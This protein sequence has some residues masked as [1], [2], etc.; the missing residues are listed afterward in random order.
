MTRFT[1]LILM[2]GVAAGLSAQTLSLGT[3]SV[4][5]GGTAHMN[6]MLTSGGSQYA[7]VQCDLV[8]DKTNLTITGVT[9]SA[10]SG[11]SKSASHNYSLSSTSIRFIVAGL[12]QDVIPDGDVVDLTIV[13]NANAPA[14]TYPV[15]VTNTAGTDPN[16]NPLALGASGGSVTVIAVLS[17]TGPSTIPSGYANETYTNTQVNAVGGT[18]PYT[19]SYSGFP[20]GMSVNSTG[21][22]TGTP[23]VSG[24]FSPQVKVTDS[25]GGTATQNYSL[26]IGNALTVTAPTGATLPVATQ[27]AAYTA[28]TAT[29]SGG[30]GSNTWTGSGFPGGLGISSAGVISGTPTANGA[31]NS[32]KITVTDAGG[33]SASQTYS[34][35]V[36]PPL[37][38]TSP[39]S[40][41]TGAVGEVYPSGVSF[42]ATGGSG[43]YTWGATGL[44]NGLGIGATGAITGTPAAGSNGNY[45]VT[46]TATDGNGIKASN[47]AAITINAALSI[48]SS[49]SLPAGAVGE[50]YTG[51]T[52]AATGGVG[53]YTWSATG[54]PPGLGIS[55]SGAI[56]GSPTGGANNY[57]PVLKV[58]DSTGFSVTQ[59]ATLSVNAALAVTAPT[60]ATLP[61]ATQGA[62][63][64]ALTA[65]ASGG[66]GSNTWT[67]SGFPAGLSISGSGSISGT[68]TANGTFNSV[69]IT[70]TDAGGGS[71]SQTY[72]LIVNPPLVVTSP[73]SPP[74]GASGEPYAGT[75]FSATGGSGTYTWTATNLPPGLTIGSTGAITGT[76]TG[77]A[78]TYTVTATAKDSNGVTA[79]NTASIQINPFLAVSCLPNPLPTAALLEAYAG[80]QC[81]ASGGVGTYTYSAST[82]FPSGININSS[83]GAVSGTP[84]VTGSFGPVVK[85]T[86]TGGGT[87]YQ[88]F[89]TLTVNPALAITNPV[90]AS[91]PVATV[92]AAYTALTAAASGGTGTNSWSGTGFPAGLSISSAG[93]ISGTPTASGTF[94][95]VK[96]TVTD[97]GG[98]S[99]SQTYSIQV[100]PQ[101]VVSAPASASLPLG[102]VGE[103][104]TSV[105]FAATGGSG[106]YTGW[107][108]TGVPPGLNFNTNTGSLSGTPTGSGGSYT[109]VVTV[110]DSNSVTANRSYS[111]TV[112]PALAVN[113]PSTLPAG[114]AS[115]AYSA[116]LTAVGGSGVYT[117][118]ATG[119]PAN[120][121]LASATG[122]IGG[123]PVTNAGSPFTVTVTVTDSASFTATKTYSLVVNPLAPLAIS[124]PSSLPAGIMNVAY[125]ATTM[126][127]TGG[128]GG[129]SWSAAGLPP[130]L[131]INPSTGT[132]SGTPATNAASPY[133]V[134]VTVT[135]SISN[136]INKTYSLVVNPTLAIIGPP[137]LPT[138]YVN[139]AYSAT[140]VIATGGSGRYTWSATGMPPGLSIN[141]SNGTVSG[142]PTASSSVAYN[143][144]V[145]VTDSNS[146]TANKGYALTI[147][148]PL[149]INGSSLPAGTVNEAYTPVKFTA[150]GGTG[151]YTWAA[152]G[153][154]PGLSINSATGTVAGTPTSNAGS[155]YSVVIS[156]SDG[157]T[158]ATYPVTLVINS[159][160]SITGPASLPAGVVNVAYPAT[161]VTASGGTGS[162]TWF[163][164]GLPPGL[165]INSSGTITG[166]PASA[167]GPSPFTPQVTVTDSTGATATRSYTVAISGSLTIS[168]PSSLPAATANVPYS[169][170]SITA[171]GGSGSYTWSASGL[172]P[173]LGIGSSSGNITGTP[174]TS[175]GSPFSVRVTV[176][177]TT[178]ATASRTYSLTVNPA[179]TISGPASL[180]AGVVGAAYPATAISASGGS[181]IYTWAAIGLPLGL[182]IGSGTGV[183]SGTPANNS[184]SPFNVLITVT[185]SNSATSS[186]SYSLA[187][188]GFVAVPSITAVL[189]AAGGQSLLA[190]GTW[191]SIYGSNFASP[192]FTDD[193]TKWIVSGKLP[194]TIDGVSVSIG[195]SPAYLSYLSPGQINM[196]IPSGVGM[197]SMSVTVTTPTGTSQPFAVTLQQVSPAFFPWPAGQP[198]AT[199]IDYTWAAKNGTI[200]G[201]TT[202][203][204]K[205]GET[206]ILWGTGF[207]PTVPPAPD[208][209]ALP[210]TPL[211]YTANPVTLTIGGAPA[212]VYATALA[213]SFGG[214]FQVVVTVPTSL[215]NGDYGVV[216]TIDGVATPTATTLT[217]HN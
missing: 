185:D 96:L 21:V 85:V 187:V 90:G 179:L 62:A 24:S 50:T 149:T 2:M 186:R 125:P 95:S 134:V 199:H 86:D 146:Y 15:T 60:G 54:L 111:M 35:T 43:S 64:T 100:N 49:A 129:Y 23:S 140:T 70:V 210:S 158:A 27:G 10:A 110:T 47:T 4:A 9:G 22:I 133:S 145:T 66:S 126:T 99:A 130:G 175:N 18:P 76:P 119:L 152:T 174:T 127:A 181:G 30:S 208:G 115:L 137:S 71:A 122:V 40:P 25:V 3:V 143:V 124:G 114:T 147:N 94:S 162:Y 17:I 45:T 141:S 117:W 93:V 81:T 106:T 197:G 217:V 155:P 216:A 203:P 206:I 83:T 178:S 72:S 166:T 8:Y 88:Q 58:T 200:N 55:S 177:D 1:S 128:N 38:V 205:P 109:V 12:G 194:T 198:V 84:T 97:I 196:L 139:Q 190:P 201:V 121:S 74:I 138:G 118:S 192:G 92:S 34:L 5:P 7:G 173:G 104:Y 131:A 120:L 77:N 183:I 211:Y 36:N 213:P 150:T 19:W 167:S 153:L 87:A 82:A 191:A 103:P 79:S 180:P 61:V 123:S 33:G 102:A 51:A 135:D 193:W 29:A 195:G 16:G 156:V 91:L 52:A 144:Q 65:T 169:G 157:L 170:A 26:S 80:A 168:G 28:L 39:S 68:P 105:Q 20:T 14:T 148:G 112:N 151:N 214:L 165:T 11:A 202:V 59:N 132:I 176:T 160:L 42:S 48:T 159:G 41:P 189:N 184:G 207:G 142:T 163:A 171:T 13:A 107:S 69:K 44:P 6:I 108:A 113:G 89:L 46:A 182:S 154:A 78:N 57:S 37:V 116:T 215:P 209:V 67:G 98:G 53:A 188:S 161:T 204:A 136:T 31:F 73:A 172:P 164:T 56:T 32:V 212:S 101:L 63:Y 75:S